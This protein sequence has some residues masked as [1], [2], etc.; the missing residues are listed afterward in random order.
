MLGFVEVCCSCGWNVG[1]C[2]FVLFWVT[3]LHFALLWHFAQ[4]CYHFME[5][6]VFCMAFDLFRFVLSFTSRSLGHEVMLFAFL[7]ITFWKVELW[8]K[9]CWCRVVIVIENCIQFSINVTFS[10]WKITNLC[11]CRKACAHVKQIAY[12][13]T[14]EYLVIVTWKMKALAC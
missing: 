10:S 14:P 2:I 4:V 5:K 6:V 13:A 12:L 8:K 9:W 11:N 7:I 1:F 3:K